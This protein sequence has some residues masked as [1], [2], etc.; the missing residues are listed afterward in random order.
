[1][2]EGVDA[3][4]PKARSV[5][6][7]APMVQGASFPRPVLLTLAVLFA[8]ATILYSA[9]WMYAIR[10]ET[11]VRLGINDQ[12]STTTR[13]ARITAVGEGGPAEQAGL[14]VDDQIVAVNG[15]SL[16]TFLRFRDAVYR[17]Q[18]GDV[19]RLTVERPGKPAPL[20]LD[21]TLGPALPSEERPPARAIVGQAVQSFPV[22]LVIVGL[23]VLFLR[24]ADRNAW[25]LALLFGG[26][27]AGAPLLELEA[28]IPPALRGFAVAYKVT[29]MGSFGPLF[30]YFFA[31]FP[32]SSPI[33]R[34]LP[35]LKQVLLGLGV[36]VSIPLGLWAL[37]TGSFQPLIELGDRVF[38]AGFSPLVGRFLLGPLGLGFVSLLWNTRAATADVRRKT[39]VIV[40]GT[41]VG[42]GPVFLL[43]AVATSLNRSSFL[44]FPFWIMAPSVLALFL[45]PLSFAYAVVRHRVLGIPQLLRLGLQYAFARHLLLSLVP[46]LAGLLMLDLLLHGDEPLIAVVRA[47]GW[48]Y[49][50]LGGLALVTQ[51][52][53]QRWLRALERTFFRERYDAQRLLG[54]VVEEVRQAGSFEQVA[55]RAVARIEVAL[56]TEFVAVLARGASETS[57]RKVA[58]A[59]AGRAPPAVSADSKLI[60]LLRVL[61]KPIEVSLST[62]SW[63]TQQLPHEETAFL[64]RSRIELLV[65]IASSPDRTQALMALGPKR[66]EEPYTG[67]DLSFLV[68]IAS[69]LALFLERP[70]AAPAPATNTF[71]ECPAC[72]TCYDTG[73]ASCAQDRAALRPIPF[74]RLLADRYRLD[75]RLGRGG[76]GTVYEATDTALERRVAAKLIRDDLV[77]SVDAA[78]RFQREARATAAF[79]HPNVVTVHDFGVAADAR[80]FLVMEL[81][82]GTNLRDAIARDG[83]LPAARTVEIMR[84]VCAAVDAA[85]EQQ[86][87]HR[88][89]KPENI[90]LAQSRTGETP[91][92]LDFGIAKFV[93]SAAFTEAE[94]AAGVLLGTWQYMSPEQLRGGTVQPA[95]DVWALSVVIYEML[96]G[97]HPFAAA[98]PDSHSAVLQG[99][100]TPLDV[101]L[102]DASIPAGAF[103]DR[104]FASDA[105]ERPSSVRAL[106][107]DLERALA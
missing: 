39:R 22:L 104:A 90:F 21:A 59:P 83:R 48:V 77:G 13:S 73:V 79:A 89:L 93:S 66:S 64:R 37:V 84:S 14:L 25:L 86:L 11:D 45:L 81:L 5:Q 42:V 47:R 107:G 98:K 34:R 18:P 100:F 62:A 36:A 40:F 49:G 10:W 33:D 74:S 8:A 76:M 41:V 43:G 30:Y 4:A 72:G 105:A 75:R 44:D 7:S 38:G 27:V 55:P 71:A 70:A 19:V 97:T 85:H 106:L 91:K 65:P 1:M 20:T 57:Y 94:T 29:L 50:V 52:Q 69:S 46:L 54:E 67:E 24:L 32:T 31:V 2:K 103:F 53:R 6:R 3:G 96:T 63:L 61:G 16:E 58:S 95:W 51:T 78:A 35:W 101:H 28:A 68:A 87:V 92:V 80:A 82:A 15:R 17:G 56:H 60:A 99:R 12:Y 23:G 9:I 26:F 88:D 102:P